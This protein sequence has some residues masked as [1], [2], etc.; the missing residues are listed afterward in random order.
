LKFHEARLDNGLQIVAEQ[1]ASVHSV[2]LGFFVRTGARDETSDVSGVSHFLEHMAFKGTERFSAE[3]V[4]R[5][6][7]EVGARYNAS[8][9]E[10]V[11]LF[12]GAILP[13]YLPRM[14]ELLAGILFPSLRQDDFDME[15]KVILEEI[16]MYDDQPTFT[17]YEQAMRAHF[18]GHPLGSSILGS[19]D[20]VGG[21]TCEQMRAYHADHYQ[22]GNILLA[23]AGNVDWDQL[24]QLAEQH[25]GGWPAG[26]FDRP[27]QEARPSGAL[28]VVTRDSS[29]HQHVMEMTPA[30]PATH[31]LRFAAELLGF[32]VGDD[33][34]SRLYWEL[35]DSGLAEAA[36][37]GYNDYDGSG[38]YL[39]YLGC[40]PDLADANLSRIHDVYESVNRDGITS[41]ELATAKNKL[42]SRIVLKSERPMGRLSALGGNW[43]YRNEYR[44]VT[45]DLATFNSVTLDD[46]R[47]LLEAYPLG[48]T[49]TVAV[50][51]LK[52]LSIKSSSGNG[53][54]SN[55][56]G[57]DGSSAAS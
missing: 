40:Q 27:V 53:S 31:E 22:A 12:Y 6:F 8:T 49:T 15:K 42:T 56:A 23:A 38:T 32:V 41:D 50:G 18:D 33:S 11:T 14:F 26:C 17:A 39:T 5:I 21:L 29:V 30:P 25:C 3:D 35:V 2:A 52:A 54:P 24:K 16:G 36:E 9:S 20:S 13:E 1:N 44:S 55:A 7:D 57:G 45:D 4:N 19:V 46:V 43:I 48:H 10:E 47:R 51:P 37:L 28:K 34:G